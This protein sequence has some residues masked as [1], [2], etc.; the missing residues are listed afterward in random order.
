[1]N[2]ESYKQLSFFL[3]KGG[4]IYVT[5]IFITFCTCD[6]R[7]AL[8]FS[9]HASVLGIFLEDSIG[10]FDHSIFPICLAITIIM[11]YVETIILKFIERRTII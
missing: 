8:Y 5:A 11:G 3:D 4:G 1:M 9:V 2:S 6:Y 7:D 10:L